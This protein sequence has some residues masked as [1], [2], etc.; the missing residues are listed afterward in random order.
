MCNL[1]GQLLYLMVFSIPFPPVCTAVEEVHYG[2]V[3][4]TDTVQ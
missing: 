1:L 3:A 2:F 4:Q